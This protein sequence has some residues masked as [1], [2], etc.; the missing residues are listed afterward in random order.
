MFGINEEILIILPFI[1]L[2]YFAPSIAATWRKHSKA[3][4]IR[5][6]NILAGWTFVGWVVAAVWAYTENNRSKKN[7]N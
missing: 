7:K 4:A 6:L 5:I 3:P 2:L 1:L